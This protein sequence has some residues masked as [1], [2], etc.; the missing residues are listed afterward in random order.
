MTASALPVHCPEQTNWFSCRRQGEA[1]C[2]FRLKSGQ[3]AAPRHRV[4]RLCSSLFHPTVPF[5]IRYVQTLM[6]PPAVKLCSR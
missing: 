2:S 1:G 6:Q 5:V 4:Q 3:A